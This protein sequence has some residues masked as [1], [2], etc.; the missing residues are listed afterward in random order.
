[1]SESAEAAVR[2]LLAEALDDPAVVHAPADTPLLAGGLELD[3]LA[4]AELV[5]ALE[6]AYGVE[7]ALADLELAS[8]RTIGTLAE[9]VRRADAP[10]TSR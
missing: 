3:S 5:V 2:R 1:M 10:D 9:H 8:L 6:S 7:I 4:T